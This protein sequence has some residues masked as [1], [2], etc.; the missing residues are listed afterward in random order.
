MP[1][2]LDARLARDGADW[3]PSHGGSDEPKSGT[4]GPRLLSDR[5]PFDD[6]E[7][8]RRVGGDDPR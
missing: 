3:Y 6:A 1:C 8:R 7:L 5:H 4:Q 2:A